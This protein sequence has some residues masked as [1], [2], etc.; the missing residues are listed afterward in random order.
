MPEVVVY[1]A[2]GR[3]PEQKEGLCRDITAAIVNNFG[4]PIEAVVVSIIDTPLHDKMKGG[5]MFTDR[6][7]TG[8]KP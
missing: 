4:A 3:T 2:A 1:C 6:A 8:G 7:R 5:V